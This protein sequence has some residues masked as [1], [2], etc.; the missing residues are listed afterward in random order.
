MKEILC[1][2]IQTPDGTILTS[3]DRHDF[4]SYVD[5]NGYEYMVDGGVLP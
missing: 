3:H 5:K 4:K 1:N 2:R